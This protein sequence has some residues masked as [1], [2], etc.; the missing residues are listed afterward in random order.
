MQTVVGDRVASQLNL[1]ETDLEAT[2]IL[3]TALGKDHFLTVI[4]SYGLRDSI[5]FARAPL[6]HF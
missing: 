2:L 5:S 3:H 4:A 6:S 1:Q